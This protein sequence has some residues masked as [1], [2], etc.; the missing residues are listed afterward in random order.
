ERPA[1]CGGM[2]GAEDLGVRIVVEKAQLGSPR[3]E[4]REAR[5]Q[6]QGEERP[7]RRR[8]AVRWSERR[9]GPIMRAHQ[10][11]HVSTTGWKLEDSSHRSAL[12]RFYCGRGT[13]A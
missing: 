2:L 9:G 3:D 10:G 8:P 1:E 11:A 4:H 12:K 7:Q 13:S 5:L 6:E